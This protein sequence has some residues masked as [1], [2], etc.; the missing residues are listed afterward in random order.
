L[1]GVAETLPDRVMDVCSTPPAKISNFN[2]SSPGHREHRWSH[3]RDVA[4]KLPD[5]V[6]DVRVL[7]ISATRRHKQVWL[8]AVFL[9]DAD[10]IFRG[11]RVQYPF[12]LE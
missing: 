8:Q 3:F 5:P 9:S 10:Q 12:A 4:P 2:R 1:S 6:A 7:E 11:P